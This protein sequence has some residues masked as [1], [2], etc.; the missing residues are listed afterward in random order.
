MLHLPVLI[1]AWLVTG[2]VPAGV[3]GPGQLARSPDANHP[4]EEP[5]LQVH[6]EAAGD[7]VD[8]KVEELS[9]DPSRYFGKRIRITA[10]VERLWDP[11][12][13]T[14]EHGEM[15]GEDGKLVVFMPGRRGLSLPPISG[16]TVTV[17]G[18]FER[19]AFG[20]A[21]RVDV[22]AAERLSRLA[23]RPEG[24]PM[25]HA[26]TITDENG[27]QVYPTVLIRHRR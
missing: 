14:L 7:V 15:V 26:D 18:M 6:A 20:E 27:L 16:R 24:M 3:H 19:F 21:R 25:I 2:A 9:E 17:V 12:L 1:S 10:T 4:Y 22:S 13:F 5:H 11:A 23:L 8:L